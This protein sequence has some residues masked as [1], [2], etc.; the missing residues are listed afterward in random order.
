MLPQ[1]MVFQ[2]QQ[3]SFVLIIVPVTFILN[4]RYLDNYSALIYLALRFN[5]NAFPLKL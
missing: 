2:K 3:R 4:E 1:I 5:E